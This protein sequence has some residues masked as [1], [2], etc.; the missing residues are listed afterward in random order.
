MRIM[1]TLHEDIHTSVT[2][3][4]VLL[5]IRAVS[6]KTYGE[7]QNTSFMFSNFFLTEHHSWDNVEK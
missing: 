5:T 4:S 3:R 1:G 7:N 6:D 2:S